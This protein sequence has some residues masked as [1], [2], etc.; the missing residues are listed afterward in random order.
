MGSRRIL[1]RARHVLPAVATSI[2]ITVPPPEH[3]SPHIDLETL[4]EMVFVTSNVG[5]GTQAFSG[6]L[7]GTGLRRPGSK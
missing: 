5:G 4:P 1:R 2:A 6:G 7:L 3:G